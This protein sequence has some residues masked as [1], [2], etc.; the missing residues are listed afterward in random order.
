MRRTPAP[1]GAAIDWPAVWKASWPPLDCRGVV[2]RARPRSGLSFTPVPPRTVR[3]RARC[4]GC[5]ALD[6]PPRRLMRVYLANRGMWETIVGVGPTCSVATTDEAVDR[7]LAV[8]A[9]LVAELTG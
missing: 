3:P 1:N 4:R 2:H 6:V 7:C 9:D 5:A 8:F